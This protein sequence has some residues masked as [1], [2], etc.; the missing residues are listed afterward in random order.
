VPNPG[1][2]EYTKCPTGISQLKRATGW[3]SPTKGTPDYYCDCAT[4]NGKYSDAGVPLNKMGNQQPH[5][6]SAYAGFIAYNVSHYITEREYL[7]VKLTEPLKAD[8][9]YFISFYINLSKVAAYATDAV[10]AY[11]S[12]EPFMDKRWITINN[13][14][15]VANPTGNILEGD[16]WH[17]ISGK[18]IA[19]GGE[20][21]LMIG[22]F[23]LPSNMKIKR[24]KG[25]PYNEQAYYYVDDV[26]LSAAK[27]DGTCA[28]GKIEADTVV[29]PPTVKTSETFRTDTLKANTSIVLNNVFF[30]TDKAN[31]LPPSYPEL[32]KLVTYLR[33]YADYAILLSG[34]TDNQGTE[35]HNQM[36][37]EARAQSVAEY[38]IK[39]GIDKRKVHYS[40]YG[41]LKPIAT[42][43]TP[44]G[45]QKNRRVE[46]R[47]EPLGK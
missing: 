16:Q 27:K 24:T 29:T 45:R 18:Y 2:E 46:F 39:K 7:Q 42:N 34:F 8:S 19:K 36:L 3:S 12:S 44:E 43:D 1:F 33:A 20:Q 4:K 40:G 31:L 35:A 10:G 25:N 11:I 41:S 14:P 13:V 47:L 32:D 28:C 9:T 37:S 22:N 23:L 6:G 5:A 21:Y 17:C 38:L 26:C 15:Q 30:E